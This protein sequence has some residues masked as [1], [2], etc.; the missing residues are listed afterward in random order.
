MINDDFKKLGIQRGFNHIE[1]SGTDTSDDVSVSLM[2]EE[3]DPAYKEAISK[4]L[5]YLLD[6]DKTEGQVRKKLKEKGFE[7]DEID[8]SVEYAKSFNYIDDLRYAKHFVEGYKDKRSLKRIRQDLKNRFVSDNII[9][10]VLEDE[11][12]DE[13]DALRNDMKK[14]LSKY[15]I[16][17]ITYEDKQ[18]IM[19]KAYRKGYSSSNI[20]KVL[21][22]IEDEGRI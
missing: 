9:D 2:Y 3:I 8:A 1:Q 4:T 11:T 18:K 10:I 14:I 6:S 16:Y 21:S 22:E 5:S 13:L 17:S 15:D 7:E 20:V 19:A 12:Y